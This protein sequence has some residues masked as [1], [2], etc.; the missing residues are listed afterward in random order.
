[1]Q[2]QGLSV[3]ARGNRPPTSLIPIN[4]A[5]TVKKRKRKT[6][7]PSPPAPGS[8]YETIDLASDEDRQAPRPL[9]HAPAVAPDVA[10]VRH[11]RNCLIS[12]SLGFFLSSTL[13]SCS[14]RSSRGTRSGSVRLCS[15]STSHSG[16]SFLAP[17]F[18]VSSTL[19]SR[20]GR[21]GFRLGC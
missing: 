20:S 15:S 11:V 4:D 18:F 9:V 10:Q 7:Q 1:M 3:V 21:E 13:V 14:G 19:V 6:K 8:S 2:A 16:E 12:D 5:G 17:E